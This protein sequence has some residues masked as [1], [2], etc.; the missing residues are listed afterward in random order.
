MS[1]IHV[2]KCNQKVLT[3]LGLYSYRLNEPTNEFY[4]AFGPYYVQFFNL[5]FLTFSSAVFTFQ[6]L[7]QINLALQ[8]VSLFTAGIQCAGM[9]ICLGMNMKKVKVLHLKLQEIVDRGILFITILFNQKKFIFVLKY[10]LHLAENG[11]YDIYWN[12]EQKC[13]K[14]T[15][16]I[17]CYIL[18]HSQVFVTALLYS[19]YCVYTG[20]FNTSVWP[21][22]FNFVAPFDTTVVWGW[23]L[24][25][26]IQFNSAMSYC[27]SVIAPTSYFVAC[28]LYNVATCDHLNFLIQ[29]IEADVKESL[30]EETSSIRYQVIRRN[31]KGKFIKVVKHHAE[32]LE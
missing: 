2:L 19:F 23:Y 29:L 22:P 20:N 28:C 25:W 10:C 17:F 18:W 4:T 5:I 8:N 7:S 9:F 12:N 15:K 26:F 1:K 16:R 3:P 6:N 13:R 30:R 27:L 11:E 31:I 14:F 21:L 24:M 32:I